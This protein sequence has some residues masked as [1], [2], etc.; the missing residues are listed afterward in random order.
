M[1]SLT[2]PQSTSSYRFPLIFNF[3]KHRLYLAFQ[4]ESTATCF[5]LALDPNSSPL[6]FETQ[7]SLHEAGSVFYAS[8]LPCYPLIRY[9]VM[10][11]LSLFSFAR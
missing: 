10:T 11:H 2:S 1:N 8:H 7:T 6:H 4:V 3:S 5:S 9:E